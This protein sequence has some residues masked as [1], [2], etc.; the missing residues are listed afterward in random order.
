M[1]IYLYM[2]ILGLASM[3]NACHSRTD[4]SE[5][6]SRS[7]VVTMVIDLTEQ[8]YRPTA[9]KILHLFDFKGNADAEATFRLRY[10]TDKRI[11]PGIDYHLRTT[12]DM[13]KD[14]KAQDPQFRN[15]N[16][17]AFYTAVENAFQNAP[18][19]QDSLAPLQNSECFWSISKELQ[20]LS[21]NKNATRYLLIASDLRELSVIHDSYS[22]ASYSSKQIAEI[23]ERTNLLPASLVGI[24]VVFLFQPKDRKQDQAF[25]ILVEAYRMLLEPKGCTVKV[26]ANL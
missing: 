15:K 7:I 3:I 23:F 13:A 6:P 26:Q 8:M 9:Q 17:K 20:E 12:A 10:I 1:K 19:F 5:I 11:N 22:F 24:T 2:I 4:V 18:G 21:K 14:N 16:I 25:G